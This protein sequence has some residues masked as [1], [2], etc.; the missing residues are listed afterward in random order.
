MDF[1]RIKQPSALRPLSGI[2]DLLTGLTITDKKFGNL[3]YGELL[4]ESL[5]KLILR[6]S[7]QADDRILD[8]GSGLGKPA[9][10]FFFQT[11]ASFVKGIE[12]DVNLG[13]IAAKKKQSLLEQYPALFQ[14]RTI[15]LEV[16]DFLVADWELPTIVYLCSTAFD[17]LLIDRITD[18]VNKTP[19][20]RM[21]YT[22]KPLGKLK[23]LRFFDVLLMEG[24]WDSPLCY[25]Y[26]PAL[27]ANSEVKCN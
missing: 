21:L 26:Q 2:L 22:L 20:I 11:A 25:I 7:I 5:E 27:R 13:A 1:F 4:P 14:G 18:K 17:D 12:I 23:Y 24:T 9:L 15:T 16:G 19:T 10:Q 6:Y 3:T 8:L